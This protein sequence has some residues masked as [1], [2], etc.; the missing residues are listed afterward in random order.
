MIRILIID[1]EREVGNFLSHLLTKNGYEV[2]VAMSGKEF[3]KVKEIPFHLA[4]IDLKLPD[5]NGLQILKEL[6]TIQPACKA[7]VMTGYSTIETAVEAIKLG[8]ND[9]IEKPF[10]DI[11]Q[12]ENQIERLITQ[13]GTNDHNEILTL[14]KKLGFIIGENENMQH[15]LTIAYKIANKNVNVL[16]E[17]ETGTGKEVLARFIHQASKREHQPFIG[18]NCGA[19]TESLLESELFGH[20]KGSFTGAT[21][22]RKGLFE[23]ANNGTLFL[24]EIAEASPQIQVK[25]L[26]VIET[27]E[28]MRIGSEKVMRTN[29]RVLA[30]SHANLA[31]AVKQNKFREDLFYRLNVVKLHLPPLRE[32]KE[33]IPLLISYFLKK[34]AEP[35]LTFTAEA[36]QLMQQYDWPGNIRELSNI[37]TRAATLAE[38]EVPV[39]T[40][41]YL[42]L[43]LTTCTRE[44]KKEKRDSLKKNGFNDEFKQCISTWMNQLVSAWENHEQVNLEEI[45]QEY[46]ELGTL[47]SKSFVKRA[48]RETLGDRKKA[49][50]LLNINT[51]KLRYLLN[52][53]RHSPN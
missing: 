7:I 26:R 13:E 30:A 35:N 27:R 16:I 41:Y 9:Y 46:N 17:G 48:L 22:L 43:N 12:I 1:D 6:K 37:I 14:A 47:I 21:Q 24:D 25:L 31:E 23:I 33:E 52:E 4:M 10:D 49:A 29:V 19:L 34:Q 39:I 8:A 44:I 42:P 3:Q 40:P 5:S 28:F 38:G 15:L 20:E 53:K 51:R 45:L 11:D 2:T 36:V 32:R 50:E 18:V